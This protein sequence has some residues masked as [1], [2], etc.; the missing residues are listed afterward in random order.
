MYFYYDN[1]G[2]L[3]TSISHGEI[4]RQGST[5]NIYLCFD[6]ERFNDSDDKIQDYVLNLSFTLPDGTKTDTKE[7]SISNGYLGLETFNKLTD[8]EMTFDFKPGHRYHTFKQPLYNT[9]K[10]TELYGKVIMHLALYKNQEFVFE[11]N[12]TFHVERT[13]GNQKKTTVITPDEYDTIL[14]MINEYIVR[15][16]NITFITTVSSDITDITEIEKPDERH[17]YRIRNADGKLEYYNYKSDDGWTRFVTGGE[18]KELHDTVDDHGIRIETLEESS[19]DYKERIETLETNSEDY[20]ERIENLEESSEDYKG[21]IETLETDSEDHKGRIETLETDSEDHKERIETLETDSK[22]Y[23]GRIENLETDSEN[24][25]GRIETLEKD[26]KTLRDD[27]DK[28]INRSSQK[29]TEIEGKV[30]TNTANIGKKLNVDFTGINVASA[31]HKDDYIVIRCNNQTYTITIE[32]LAELISSE[33]DY[34]KGY[35]TTLANLQS[36]H[37]IGEPGDYA[38]VGSIDD[39]QFVQYIWDNDQGRWEE[40]ISGQYVGTSAFDTFQARLADGSI[41]VGA[42]KGNVDEISE[43]APL[44][45]NVEINGNQYALP[46]VALDFLG[47]AV[48]GAY[49]LGAIKIN[50]DT[51]NVNNDIVDLEFSDENLPDGYELG[52]VIIGGTKWNVLKM[53]VVNEKIQELK[54]YIDSISFNKGEFLSLEALQLK[55][56]FGKPGD[57]AFVNTPTYQGDIMLMYI[58]DDDSGVWKETTSEQ[59][60]LN[61][62]FEQFRQEIEDR[63]NNFNGGGGGGVEFL[64]NA[65]SIDSTKIYEVPIFY[66]A[67]LPLTPFENPTKIEKIYI[68]KKLPP[69]FVEMLCY[70]ALLV[71]GLIDQETGETSS[72]EQYF[73][74][75]YD[76]INDIYYDLGIFINENAL[77]LLADV[78]DGIILYD[79][80]NGWY[81]DAPDYIEFNLDMYSYLSGFN[82]DQVTSLLFATIMSQIFSI[83]PFENKEFDSVAIKKEYFHLG[84]NTFDQYSFAWSRIGNGNVESDFVDVKTLEYENGVPVGEKDKI[85]RVKNIIKSGT[86]VENKPVPTSGTLKNVFINKDMSMEDVVNILKTLTY[87]PTSNSNADACCVIYYSMNSNGEK[88]ILFAKNYNSYNTQYSII[89]STNSGYS[90]LFEW[91]EGVENPGWQDNT[92]FLND[93]GSL[94]PELIGELF[95]GETVIGWNGAP[96]GVENDKIVD[97]IYTK[98]ETHNEDYDYSYHQIKNGK[99]QEFGA[100]GPE[101]YADGNKLVINTKGTGSGSGNTGGSGGSGK[102]FEDVEQL[103]EKLDSNLIYRKKISPEKVP[104][105]G[106]NIETLYFNTLMP[107][108]EVVAVIENANLSWIDGSAFGETDYNFYPILLIDASDENNLFNAVFQ[109]D[110]MTVFVIAKGKSGTSYDGFY[111]IL[112]QCLTK[113]NQIALFLSDEGW[114]TN[115]S[116]EWSFNLNSISELQGIPVGTQND[117]ITSLINVNGLF[118]AKTDY[119]NYDGNNVNKI[120]ETDGLIKK[121]TFYNRP[122]LFNW[123]TAHYTKVLKVKFSNLLGFYCFGPITRNNDGF[124]AI[125]GYNIAG[126]YGRTPAIVSIQIGDSDVVILDVELLDAGHFGSKNTRTTTDEKWETESTKITLYYIEE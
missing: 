80:E 62:T 97:L 70:Y 54:D 38:F 72:G 36:T 75:A 45:I 39:S 15:F 105:D 99:W 94:K 1:T 29:D 14:A 33:V 34:F 118:N 32:Y 104:N 24:H 51:W 114:N 43:D 55:H 49:K 68:N 125:S 27:V 3:R 42:V 37:P 79:T 92:N 101:I 76:E 73:L 121:R 19:E 66:D 6:E 26:T 84:F 17:L 7:L 31:V 18:F 107:K 120:N 50:G 117:K 98:K 122:D 90:A 48:E 4:P 78:D 87:H 47:E 91:G 113:G 58:W 71:D 74:E 96:I 82:D 57:F 81:N 65:M 30:N 41:H 52:S 89:L 28:E 10:I 13:V 25:K 109:Y 69:D 56:P 106:S 85:Y 23:K 11:E 111:A 40:T 2:T 63:L 8:S 110:P 67:E 20:K 103:P 83:K 77:G 123:L 9:D 12:G 119:Y 59:Y 35:H 126:S 64:F 46:S 86:T 16:N 108:E 116:N 22:S 5:L 88:I 112:I 44:L 115:L 95:P 61:S 100:G 60:V 21:R 102:V 53:S 93:D 124:G